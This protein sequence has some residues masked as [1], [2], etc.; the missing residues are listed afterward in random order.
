LIHIESPQN[1]TINLGEFFDIWGQ[2]F[3]NNQIFGLKA[4]NSSDRTLTVY[5]NG[6]AINRTSYRDIP[7]LNHEDIVIIYGTRPP[8]I[9]Q[10]KFLY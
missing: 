3:N 9:P 7:I 5:L 1:N 2:K 10:Y 4:D 6:T 8:E